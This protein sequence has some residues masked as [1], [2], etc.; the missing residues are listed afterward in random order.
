M[1]RSNKETSGEIDSVEETQMDEGGGAESS[2]SFG[3]VHMER[4]ETDVVE[5]TQQDDAGGGAESSQSYSNFPV[6]R[7]L[8]R[9]NARFSPPLQE[10]MAQATQVLTDEPPLIA[11]SSSQG[12]EEAPETTGASRSNEQVQEDAQD[13]A[14]AL[15]QPL[16]SD[17]EVPSPT[18]DAQVLVA[19]SSQ[20]LASGEEVPAT[21]VDDA[22]VLVAASLSVSN[23]NQKVPSPSEDAQVLVAASPQPLAPSVQVPSP[24]KD[25]QVSAT[26]SLST[27]KPNQD[28]HAAATVDARVLVSPLSQ[29]SASISTRKRKMCFQDGRIPFFQCKMAKLQKDNELLMLRLDAAERRAL[30]LEEQNLLLV[31]KTAAVASAVAAVTNNLSGP[32]MDMQ[33]LLLMQ[34]TAAVASVVAAVANHTNIRSEQPIHVHAEC[35]SSHAEPRK[36]KPKTIVKNTLRGWQKEFNQL[37]AKDGKTDYNG[38]DSDNEFSAVELLGAIRAI[39]SGSSTSSTDTVSD[40]SGSAERTGGVE[41]FYKRFS[42]YH[43]DNGTKRD[44]MLKELKKMWKNGRKSRC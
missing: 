13:L 36:M 21:T 35:S 44:A 27:F 14:E 12:N 25:A 34:R 1:R 39:G 22:Q 5:E 16:A 29:P 32:S 41:L 43:S 2:M 28:V 15:W 31:Q 3:N 20:P 37:V 40:H 4:K 9:Q 17:E 26:P 7:K 38:D 10:Q 42:Q 8:T 24:S 19:A 6:R 33:N 23:N 30:Q 18:E 11:R